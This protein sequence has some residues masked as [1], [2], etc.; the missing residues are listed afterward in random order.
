MASKVNDA[1]TVLLR[2]RKLPLQLLEEPSQRRAGAKAA[3]QGL[4]ATQPFGETFSAE[5]RQKR[6]RLAADGLEALV[7]RAEAGQESFEAKAAAA[8]A[9]IAAANG[10]AGGGAAAAP[11]APVGDGLDDLKDA[12]REALFEKGQSKRIWGELYKVLDSS[13]VVIQVLDARDP[14]GTRCRFIERHIRRNAR[15]KHLLLLLNKCDLV[16]GLAY[17]AS[18]LLWPVRRVCVVCARCVCTLPSSTPT[19]PR[20][21]KERDRERGGGARR[22]APR[23]APQACVCCVW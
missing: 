16:S 19:H 7:A 23:R 11:L 2:E 12:A 9:A 4:L 3:R 17:A 1:Y 14:E 20:M 22:T 21:A 5:R 10:G 15:H 8:P 6:P 18:F 13:D